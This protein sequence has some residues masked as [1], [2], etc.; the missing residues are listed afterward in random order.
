MSSSDFDFDIDS[1]LAEFSSDSYDTPAPEKPIFPVQAPPVTPPDFPTQAPPVR[2]YEPWDDIQLAPPRDEPVRYTQASSEDLSGTRLFTAQPRPAAGEPRPAGVRASSAVADFDSERFAGGQTR[3]N[4]QRFGASR[5]MRQQ[6]RAAGAQAKKPGFL[7]IAVGTVFAVITLMCLCW[8]AL[9]VH[10]DT[11]ASSAEGTALKLD[12]IKKLDS[13]ENNAKSDALGDLTYIKKVYTIAESDTVAP[14]PDPAKYGETTDVNVIQSVIDSAAPLLEG[15]ELI[16]DPS[17]N[18][19]PGTSIRYYCDDTILAIVWQESVDS[20]CCTCAEIK[21]AHG[22]QIRRKVADDTYSSS[23]QYYASDM[24]KQCNAVVTI[25]GD[26]Y[27]FRNLGITVFQRQL[28]R[29]NP[30][31]VD[32]CFINSAGD[33]IFS[34][35]GELMS[36]GETQQF[37]T[38]NDIIFA[39]AFGPVL[40]KDGELQ[41]CASYP[42]GEIDTEYSR[43]SISQVDKLHYFLMTINHTMEGT[44]RANINELAEILYN[45]GVKNAYALD[46]GQTSEIIMQGSP[47]N[48][49][50]FGNERLVSD[51][52]Y[53]ATAIPESEVGS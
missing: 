8:V 37:I 7:G 26:F 38:D 34:R 46:G 3:S 22:S 19:Y 35:A 41:Y 1:I 53:F 24:S 30:A 36:E 18:F 43:S 2:A 23:N 40:V 16:W 9:N 25:N 4:K 50:D 44:P 21:T 51:I 49:V 48:H 5:D 33:M 27:A 13:Y 12:L 10:P 28:Y 20:K 14:K 45:K 11:G 31:T 6:E 47:V 29:N 52:I 17:A 15:Q 39:L 32:S 42:I